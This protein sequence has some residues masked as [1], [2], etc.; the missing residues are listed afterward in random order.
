MDARA[1]PLSV[2]DSRSHPRGGHRCRYC[3]SRWGLTDHDVHELVLSD[4]R[5]GFEALGIPAVGTGS[6]DVADLLVLR[7]S[8]VPLLVEVKTRRG[9]TRPGGLSVHQASVRDFCGRHDYGWATLWAFGKVR[10][11]PITGRGGLVANRLL[12]PE[13]IRVRS[14]VA[15]DAEL[16]NR[17]WNARPKDHGEG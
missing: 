12:P 13:T 15:A 2:P 3:N 8:G 9:T 1:S 7:K 17:A 6:F 10:R 14:S 4:L 5:R 11:I 16:V